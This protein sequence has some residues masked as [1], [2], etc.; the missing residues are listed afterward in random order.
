MSRSFSTNMDFRRNL[1]LTLATLLMALR[2]ET[3]SDIVLEA[4]PSGIVLKDT[5]ALLITNCVTYTRRVV[6]RLDCQAIYDQHMGGR[7]S[8]RVISAPLQWFTNA[9]I[10][11]CNQDMVHQIKQLQ[12]FELTP[13]ELGALTERERRFLGMFLGAAAAVGSVFGLTL[14]GMNTVS[15]H[16]LRT[17]M[18]ELQK[19]QPLIHDALNKQ[20]QYGQQLGK[21]LK[22]TILMVN[23]QNEMFNR[24]QA[25]LIRLVETVGIEVAH[26]QVVMMIMGDVLREVGESI[27]SLSQG[28][29]PPYLVSLEMVQKILSQLTGE[30][31][32]INQ[33]HLAYALGGALPLTV[34]PEKRE[35]SFLITLPFVDNKYIYRLKDVVNVGGWHGDTHV[36]IT[37][38]TVI[39]YH[40]DTPDLYL[41]PNLKMC[42][43]TKGV[44]YLCPSKPFIK[45]SIQGICG[46]KPMQDASRCSAVSTARNQITETQGEVVGHRWLVNTP[47]LFGTLRYDK[48]D[49]SNDIQLP[50][51]TFWLTVP[52][53]STFHVGDLVLYYLSDEAY[54][55]ELEISTF[56]DTHVIQFDPTTLR[57]LEMAPQAISLTALDGFLETEPTLLAESHYTLTGSWSTSDTMLI[58]LILLG[59]VLSAAIAFFFGRKHFASSRRCNRLCERPSGTPQPAPRL[60]ITS[61]DVPLQ[62][63]F[64]GDRGTLPIDDA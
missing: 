26:S 21:S 39:A 37:T 10:N 33:A 64:N 20:I 12:K 31:I 45:S 19:E 27:Q 2:A 56:F 44:H 7:T 18:T 42:V 15:L 32:S 52:K 49:T 60:R 25:S 28:R 9:I 30:T 57:Q 17:Q 16:T 13:E 38:P 1:I 6:V 36:R 11:H 5:S 40:E 48:H 63:P 3:Q 51:Q 24:S 46:L 29:I 61:E 35:L 47:A 53:G 62:A 54:V 23:T 4:S 58:G 41:A 34:D 43:L 59:Y 50:A 8:H 55:A 14:G 22:E